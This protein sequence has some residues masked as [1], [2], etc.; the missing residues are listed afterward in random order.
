MRHS[1]KRSF[2]VLV[3][4]AAGLLVAVGSPPMAQAKSL[5]VCPSG[6]QFTT[7]AAA[8]G[9]AASGSQIAIGPGT[10][11]GGFIVDKKVTL[12][13]VGAEQTAIS[14][15]ISADTI[16]GGAS[17]NYGGGIYNTG[18]LTLKEST[19]SG[20]GAVKGG[21]IYSTGTL[22]LKGSTVSGNYAVNGGGFDNTGTLTL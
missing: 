18:T 9:V 2:A 17:N 19:V 3:V 6:C 14:G 11:S 21:G 12:Y 13:G 7:I 20:N 5:T 15:T 10:Y 8:L 22:S 16:S 1:N 4:A